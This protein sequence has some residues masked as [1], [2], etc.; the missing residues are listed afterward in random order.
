MIEPYGSPNDPYTNETN[1]FVVALGI[2]HDNTADGMPNLSAPT[3]TGSFG[4]VLNDP[5][6]N[7]YTAMR[8][9][10]VMDYEVTGTLSDEAYSHAVMFAHNVIVFPGWQLKGTGG[11][12]GVI[13]DTLVEASL[14]L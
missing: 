8:S 5:N 10:M 14:F 1:R 4:G 3:I 7:V 13:C 9:V 11:F 6:G 12:Y 2:E